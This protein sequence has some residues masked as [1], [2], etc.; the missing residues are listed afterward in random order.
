[1]SA[2]VDLWSA[3]VEAHRGANIPA[4]VVLAMIERLSGGNDDLI[5][6]AGGRG[7][8]QISPATAATLGI[9]AEDLLDPA[10][11]IEAGVSLLEQRGGQLATADPSLLS[12]LEDLG[13]LTLAA[14]W[15]GPAKILTA[16]RR[17][18]TG[19]SAA[20]VLAQPGLEQMAPF[21][22]D[23]AGR[24]KRIAAELAGQAAPAGSVAEGAAPP[25]TGP[26]AAGSAAE[27]GQAL[28][29]VAVGDAEAKRA[30]LRKV[31]WIGGLGAVILG[32]VW[33]FRQREA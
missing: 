2:V 1:M 28:E 17:L 15:F 20:A 24:E 32:G 25:L 33:W 26:G 19:A 12:R 23:L 7:L 9:A 6:P 3:T 8:L 21:V 13:M 29:L 5:G 16:I 27:N 4:S 22:A 10:V 14:Y 11:N 18:G 30:A 31:L